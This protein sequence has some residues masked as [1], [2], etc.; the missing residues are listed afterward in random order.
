MGGRYEPTVR[1]THTPTNRTATVNGIARIA[2]DLN[3]TTNRSRS[4]ILFN[5]VSRQYLTTAQVVNQGSTALTGRVRIVLENLPVG[6]TLANV[7]GTTPGGKPFV[8]VNLGTPWGVGRTLRAAL[9][10]LN[11]QRQAISFAMRVFHLAN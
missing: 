9:R 7:S 8:E 1:I 5:R 4:A 10:F 2:R 3:A 11:P 6:V